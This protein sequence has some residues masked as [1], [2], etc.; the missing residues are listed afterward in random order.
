[1]KNEEQRVRVSDLVHKFNDPCCAHSM[2][3]QCAGPQEQACCA[4][5]DGEP[6]PNDK[7][8][9]EIQYD[10]HNPRCVARLFFF[11]FLFVSFFFSFLF[12]C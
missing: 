12:F 4:F 8:V 5:R 3:K 6:E 11:F 9:T 10:V 1:M 2:R 7:E